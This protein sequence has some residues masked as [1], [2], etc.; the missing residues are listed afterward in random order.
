MTSVN[1]QVVL[2]VA[3][4]VAVSA[5]G[6]AQLV[7]LQFGTAGLQLSPYYH[8]LSGGPLVDSGYLDSNGSPASPFLRNL[9]SSS[10]GGTASGNGRVATVGD[11]IHAACMTAFALG[12]LGYW[13]DFFTSGD[14]RTA[15]DPS[16]VDFESAFVLADAY[17][18]A[19]YTTAALLLV[20]QQPAAVPVGIMAGGASIYLGCMDLLYDLQH[21]KFANMDAS[22]AFEA[23]IIACSFGLGGATIVRFSQAWDRLMEGPSS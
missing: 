17:L 4:A 21:N 15:A 7:P 18:S 8:L 14:V 12:T 9:D 20:L 22:M 10:V 1:R 23:F 16:Y 5:V 19:S 13:A 2:V 6:Y 11:W 3:F